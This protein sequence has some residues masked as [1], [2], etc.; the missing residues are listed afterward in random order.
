MTLKEQIHKNLLAVISLMV[1]LAALGYNTWRNERTEHNRNLR[2]A[3]FEILLH[4]GELQR[5]TYLAHFDRDRREGNPR[6]GWTEVMVLKDLSELMPGD[7]RLRTD[8]LLT[9]WREHWEELGSDERSVTVIDAAIDDV[10]QDTL[11]ILRRL[12]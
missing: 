7:Q 5:V 12:D 9:A 3:G 8:G 2:T 10:R 6:K 4:V 1:A 11:A